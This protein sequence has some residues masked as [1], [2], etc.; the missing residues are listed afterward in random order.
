MTGQRPRMP[1][2]GVLNLTSPL[3]LPPAPTIRFQT[4]LPGS[5]EALPQ[6]L[7]PWQQCG[8][9]QVGSRLPRPLLPKAITA[10]PVCE[11]GVRALRRG[12]RWPR[13]LGGKEAGGSPEMVESRQ[14]SCGAEIAGPFWRGTSIS[15]HLSDCPSGVLEGGKGSPTEH[16]CSSPLPSR[17]R[18]SK[19]EP[20]NGGR[21]L[22]LPNS[23]K[24]AP[25]NPSVLPAHVS[26]VHA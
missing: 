3:H 12:G 19:P 14:P 5:H 26:Q 24:A 11:E 20:P 21:A 7:L 25:R 4:C 13:S 1:A 15:Q 22:I 18:H 16:I 9:P 6:P 23:R 10:T 2:V 8:F 17:A